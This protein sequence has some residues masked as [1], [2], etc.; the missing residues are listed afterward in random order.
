M[1]TFFT[2]CLLPEKTNIHML[3]GQSEAFSS[4]DSFCLRTLSCHA[5]Y[6][7]SAGKMASIARLLELYSSH[8]TDI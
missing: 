1:V 4:P 8:D 3:R 5:V 2:R 7:P 6:L